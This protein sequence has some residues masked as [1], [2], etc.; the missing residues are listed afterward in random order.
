MVIEVYPKYKHQHPYKSEA[1]GD[2]SIDDESIVMM[3][4]DTEVKQPEAKACGQPWELAR[5]NNRFSPGT[6]RRNEPS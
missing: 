6:S 4:A 5:A 2:L 3:E 1:E